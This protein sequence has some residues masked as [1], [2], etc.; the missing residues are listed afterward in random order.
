MRSLTLLD[1]GPTEAFWKPSPDFC[2][3]TASSCGFSMRRFGFDP[4]KLFPLHVYLE[5]VC[6]LALSGSASG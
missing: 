4:F 1:P 5:L 6:W 2:G 3:H